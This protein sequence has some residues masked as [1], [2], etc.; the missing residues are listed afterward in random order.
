MAE[1]RNRLCGEEEMG[2]AEQVVRGGGNE[3]GRTGSGNGRI[4]NSRDVTYMSILCY[5]N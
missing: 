5:G 3:K 2:K 4:R 1:H